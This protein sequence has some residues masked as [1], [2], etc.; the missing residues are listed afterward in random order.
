VATANTATGQATVSIQYT[1]AVS[2]DADLS[3]LV[4]SSGSLSPV[5]AS[6]TTSYA[7]SVANGVSSVTVTPTASDAGASIRVNGNP[8]TS[9]QASSAI[10]LSVGTNTITILV[11][12]TDTTTTKTYTITVTR[13]APASSDADLTNLSLSSG[14]LSPGFASATTSYSASVADAVSSVTVTPTASD[15]GASIT[16]NGSAVTSGQASGPIS[17]S[18][19]SNTITTVVTAVDTTTKTYIVT[20]T[21]GQTTELA[22]Q[23]PPVWFQAYSRPSHDAPCREG[24]RPSYAWW[25]NDGRG[26]WTCERR[27]HAHSWVSDWVTSPG[28]FD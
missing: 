2:S 27:L 6:G 20:I 5:F 1:A 14:S 25:P 24:Y 8:V 10:S 23:A 18:V 16:V 19:G 11:T 21:R 26:G 3:N 12:A 15:A 28:F 13:A 9:G 17:L 7:S 4:L 22:S